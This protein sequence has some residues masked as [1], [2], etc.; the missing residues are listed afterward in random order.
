MANGKEYTA[1]EFEMSG[2]LRALKEIWKTNN[3][4]MD[5]LNDTLKDYCKKNEEHHQ[6]L[7]NKHDDI[8][9]NFEIW[10]ESLKTYINEE[11]KSIHGK[12]KWIWGVSAGVTGIFGIIV[13]INRMM[14]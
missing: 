14:N 10:R 6:L 4:K 1:F 8:K 13:V 5:L 12:F 7:W 2:E 11:F 9:K 3:E